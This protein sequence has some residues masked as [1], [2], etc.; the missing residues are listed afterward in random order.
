MVKITRRDFLKIA[1]VA[2]MGIASFIG[3]AFSW[4]AVE[5]SKESSKTKMANKISQQTWVSFLAGVDEVSMNLNTEQVDHLNRYRVREV[6]P[7]R[8]EAPTNIMQG[9]S[10]MRIETL[11][12]PLLSSESLSNGSPAIQFHGVR[13]NLHYTSEAERQELSKRSLPELE[14]SDHTTAVLIPIGKSEEWWKLAQDQRQAYFQKTDTHPG[15]TAIGLKYVDRVSRK[16]YHSRYLNTPLDYDFLTYFEFEDIYENDFKTLLAELRD[17][18]N[19]PE[20]AYVNLEY[21][22]WMTKTG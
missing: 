22:I 5:M 21:E 17:I 16:L 8:G 9:W 3:G 15:H 7:V 10:V 2:G 11:I 18:R 13:Q 4:K 1:G 6:V 20:W 19:N 14:P 12:P